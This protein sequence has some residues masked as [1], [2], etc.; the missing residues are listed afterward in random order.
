MQQDKNAFTKLKK[1]ESKQREG[2]LEAF[3]SVQHSVPLH[4]QKS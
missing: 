2:F 1:L 4:M 3:V